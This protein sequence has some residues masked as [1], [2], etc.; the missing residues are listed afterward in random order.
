MPGYRK[1]HY[2]PVSY[3]RAWSPD[4]RRIHLFD[5]VSGEDRLVGMKSVAQGTY[6]ND[7]FRREQGVIV[8]GHPESAFEDAFAEWETNLSL[9]RKVALRVAANEGA[10]TLDERG[11]M[12]ICAAVQ[13]LRTQAARNRLLEEAMNPDRHPRGLLAWLPERIRRRIYE[14]P[15]L[16]REKISAWQ[17]MLIWQSGIVQQMAVELYHYIWVI[18]KNETPWPFYTSD[19]PVA[20]I[21]HTPGASPHFIDPSPLP[22]SHAEEAVK[23]LFSGRGDPSGLQLIYPLTPQCALTM[24][25]PRDFARE[26]GDKQGKVLVLGGESARIY[27]SAIAAHAT[28]QVLAS[29][30]DFA[31]A[32]SVV[33]VQAARGGV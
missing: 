27:N 11:T 14:D 28:R 32:R 22:D 2:V 26:L 12:S 1:Q 8:D 21:T 4:G 19:A 33:Q 24:Y 6:F 20:A 9:M 16:A 13:L 5:K 29:N 15:A 7:A 18:A 17:M 23:R 10:G 30:N 31:I 3:L 25:H